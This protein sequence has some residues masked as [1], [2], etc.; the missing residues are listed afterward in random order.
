M[1]AVDFRQRLR[2]LA[3]FESSGSPV[4]SVYLNTGWVDEHQ[5]ERVRIFVKNALAEARG[6]RWADRDD[7]DWIERQSGTLIERGVFEDANG[8]VL[9]ACGSASLRELLPLRVP[10]DDTFVVDA[11]PYVRPLA[12]IVDDT[13]PALIVFADGVSARLIALDASGVTDET[14]LQAE[15]PGRHERGGWA[16]LAQSR[17][18]RHILE[19]R[20]QHFAAVAAA[21]GA[22]TERYDAHH[23]V[24]VAE[25]RSAAALRKHL[26]EA[27]AARIAGV[28]AGARHESSPVIADRAAG[29]LARVAQQA[30]ERRVDEALADAAEGSTAVAGVPATVGAVNRNAVRHLYVL[31]TFREPGA[32]CQDC[33]AL[34]RGVHFTC[35]FCGRDTRTTELGEALVERVL[36]SGG[37]VTTLESHLP[38]AGHGGVVARLRYAA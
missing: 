28:V 8:A 6:R 18:E 27:V 35:P 12:G 4:V 32:V 7:L 36:A 5:R 19:H 21:I 37:E 31:T 15:V 33:G 38:L 10:F 17:D 9:F 3:R 25:P 23:I 30:D 26:P 20:E 13:P 24:L 1:S 34:Q 22:W 11:R 2:E 16:D 29:V 14:V